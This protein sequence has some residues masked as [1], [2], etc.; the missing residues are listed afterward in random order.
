ML[1]LIVF[2]CQY[3]CNWLPGKT[4]LR[5]DLLCVEW[6]VKPP[7][8][9]THPAMCIVFYFVKIPLIFQLSPNIEFFSRGW[10]HESCHIICVLQFLWAFVRSSLA[11]GLLLFALCFVTG[12]IIKKEV[13][14]YTSCFCT[15]LLPFHLVTQPTRRDKTVLSRLDP[16]SMS[17]VSSVL[18]VGTQLETRQNCLVLLSWRCEHNCRQNKTLLSRLRRRCEHAI[19]VTI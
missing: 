15:I 18:A 13:L 3:Q 11:V 5:N 16:V 19:R 2:G 10:K 6:D 8:S 1:C 17:F 7:H 4:R 9:L 14:G 12:L